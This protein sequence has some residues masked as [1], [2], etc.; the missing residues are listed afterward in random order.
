MGPKR[1]SC[2]KGVKVL[3]RGFEDLAH[4]DPR[5]ACLLAFGIE[6]QSSEFVSQY[7][8]VVAV[9][10]HAICQ[11]ALVF[12]GGVWFL[13]CFICLCGRFRVGV[14]PLLLARGRH[15]ALVILRVVCKQKRDGV[16]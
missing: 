6:R 4:L 15:F 8:V 5:G 11:E 12:S 3:E 1:L 2:E 10:R 9:K 16:Y 7:W 14:W 13:V